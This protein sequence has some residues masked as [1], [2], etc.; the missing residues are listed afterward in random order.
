MH[1]EELD[2]RRKLLAREPNSL[3]ARRNVSSALDYLGNTL[4][5]SKDVAGARAAFNE[6][7]EL[8]RA[9][10]KAD[11]NNITSLTDL[12]WSLNRLG[13]LDR[14]TS[15]P[16][17]AAKY[18]EEALG[19]QRKLIVREPESLVRMRALASI[20]EQARIGT[21]PH[22]RLRQG[23]GAARGGARPAPQAVQARVRT[24]TTRCATCRWRSTGSATSC[25]T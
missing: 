21:R 11:P 7:L 20:V 2:I 6:Q 15:K 16:N 24:T 3:A 22:Q 19:I 10:A 25:V 12:A 5:E 1:R 14:D 23:A 8:D 4:R 17:E 9:I 18:Y 13:D